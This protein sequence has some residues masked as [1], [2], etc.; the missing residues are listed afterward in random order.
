MA[1]KGNIQTTSIRRF[2]GGIL[3]DAREQSSTGCRMCTGF[4]SW[5]H[6]FR[7]TPYR[8]TESGDTGASTSQKQAFQLAYRSASTDYRIFGLGVVSGTAKA[9]VLM[10]EITTTAN[11][12]SDGGWTTPNNNQSSTGTTS[13]DL[14]AYYYKTGLIYGA[15]A[16]THFWAFDTAGGA[17]DDSSYIVSYTHVAQGF[18]HPSDDILYVPYDNK[19][20]YK[21]GASAWATATAQINT[22]YY[23]TSACAYGNLVALG[24][25][26]LAGIGN[27]RVWLWDRDTS[28]SV[29]VEN[30]DWGPGVLKVL[31]E[32]S[33]DLV[34]V[35]FVGGTT[36]NIKDRFIFRRYAGQN[37]SE[38]LFE[39]ECDASSSNDIR[40]SKQKVDGRLFFLMAATIDGEVREGLWSVGKNAQGV[41]TLNH[42]LTPN[43]GTALTSGVLKGFI[44]VGDYTLIS[45]VD[46]GTYAVSKTDNAATYSATAIRE[47]IKYTNDDS[48]LKKKL[49]GVTVMYDPLPTAGSVTLKYKKDED[50]SWTTIFTD[51]TDSAISHSAVNIESTGVPLPEYQ[52]IQ[53]RIESTGGA[54]ITGLDFTSEVIDKR[55]Y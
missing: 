11:D 24:A 8:S 49:L 42:E 9:E 38:Q 35:S 50:T 18:V 33:G 5:S 34:G 44:K 39:L 47:T 53:F 43:N 22:A 27:S 54:I 14:F 19:I 29:F 21:N 41:W 13:F 20:A 36:T 40:I 52:E 31:E 6:P 25:A 7:L 1:T 12:L 30:I 48:S 4:N 15:A 28:T 16:G 32:I 45:Y 10:K 17:W 55:P 3:N 2:D 37:R 26:P 51:G 46:N 23:G